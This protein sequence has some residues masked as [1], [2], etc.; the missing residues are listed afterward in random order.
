MILD[1][2]TVKLTDWVYSIVLYDP[3][4]LIMKDNVAEEWSDQV[5]S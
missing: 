1:M 3:C 5:L 4:T 2:T